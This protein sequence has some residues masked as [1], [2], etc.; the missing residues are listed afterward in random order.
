MLVNRRQIAGYPYA[1]DELPWAA[2]GVVRD[3]FSA[4]LR[5][6]AEYHEAASTVRRE[7]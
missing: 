1:V 7:T 2:L 4:R 5:P 6:Y 3:N